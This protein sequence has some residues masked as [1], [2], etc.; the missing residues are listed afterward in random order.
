ML[1]TESSEVRK[2][3]VLIKSLR[4]WMKVSCYG[5]EVN[6]VVLSLHL[7][8]VCGEVSAEAVGIFEWYCSAGL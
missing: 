8:S 5:G 2:A 7:I 3:R 6:T 4:P 1:I